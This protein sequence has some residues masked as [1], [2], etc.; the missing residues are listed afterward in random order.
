ME[1]NDYVLAFDHFYTTNHIQILKSVLPFMDNGSSG[2]LPA[3]IKYMEFKYTLSLSKKGKDAFTGGIRA[4]GAEYGAKPGSSPSE[5]I[6][7]IYKAVRKYLSPGEEKSFQQMMSA[8]NTMKN[9]REMQ[10]MM[11]LFQNASPDMDL[12]S[13]MEN[14]SGGA[15][16]GGMNINEM[17]EIIKMFG[18]GGNENGNK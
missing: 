3:L 13:M 1:D 8:I 15:G 14:M 6:E 11:E 10:Q 5:N 4:C 17:M 2:M 12:S 18:I 9:M 7:N 16:I